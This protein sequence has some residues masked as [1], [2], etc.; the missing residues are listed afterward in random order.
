MNVHARTGN[1]LHVLITC[2][3]TTAFVMTASS[4]FAAEI[5]YISHRG[6][7]FDAPEGT[8]PAYQLAVDRHLTGVKLDLRYSKDKVIVL[9]H[10]A[11]LKRTTGTDFVIAET[12]YAEMKEKAVFKTVGKYAGE[13]ILTFD[14]TLAIVKN[15]PILFIDFKYY[16][17][18]IVQDAFERL[19]RFGI[20]H[21]RVM[22]AN[23]NYK[24]LAGMKKQYPDVRTVAHI[25]YERKK[26]GSYT[27]FGTSCPD[28]TALANAIL[29]KK[30]ECDLFGV[31]IKAVREIADKELISQLQKG[32][33]WVS[34]WFVNK[35]SQAI[36]YSGEG[37][38]AFVTDCGGKMHDTLQKDSK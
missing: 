35:P 31:N 5:A 29:A 6:E 3:L 37:A 4:V 27:V 33:L 34:I 9:S 26:D 10:D 28:K 13:K 22:L 30:K 18:E 36:Y 11:S 24:A 23:F 38:N 7:A 21:S 8:R 19:A 25:S 17:P 20:P 14:E 1:R 12:D 2:I 16:S 15:S 32:G